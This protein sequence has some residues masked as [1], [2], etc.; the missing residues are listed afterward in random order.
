[1]AGAALVLAVVTSLS[2]TASSQPSG[3]YTATADGRIVAVDFRPVPGIVFD[4]LVDAGVGVAQAQLDSLG[5]SS[6][7][8]SNAYPSQS[9]VLLPGLIGGLSGGAT[10]AL[11]PNYPLISSSTYPTKP[12]QRVEAGTV[13]LE[14]TSNGNSSR[15]NGTD[16]VNRAESAVSFDATSDTVIARSETNVA[17]IRLSDVLTIFGVRSFAEVR[18]RVGAVLQRSSGIEV[19]S[20]SILGQRV[21]ITPEILGLRGGGVLAPLLAALAQQGTTIEFFPAQETDDGIT[22]GGLVIH[23][24]FRPP[25]EVASGIES[26][27]TEVRLGG[28]AA[29]VEN[30]AFGSSIGG[31]GNAGSGALGTTTGAVSTGAAPVA[32]NNQGQLSTPLAPGAPSN[33]PA[34]TSSAL[35]SSAPTPPTALVAVLHRS[36]VRFYPVLFLAAC[37]L[38]AIVNLFRHFAVRVP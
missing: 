4:Q 34:P 8:T 26:I 14:A 6:A 17:A 5:G 1:L 23:N 11:I 16:G 9:V 30:R 19:S 20:L 3:T 12:S 10:S 21:A 37:L 25:P 15:G 27:E 33:A 29:R 38:I 7:F 32:T 18:Q 35:A 36:V 22:A 31:A 13:V 24:T 2:A 28:N